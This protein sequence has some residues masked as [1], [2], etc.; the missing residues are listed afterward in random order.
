M[1][2]NR[3][4]TVIQNAKGAFLKDPQRARPNE[5]AGDRPL[6]KPPVYLSKEEK[7][8]WKE[9]AEQL[10]PGVA[11]ESDRTMFELLVRLKTQMV[12]NFAAMRSADKSLLK[13]L[14]SRFA[15]S[16]ADRSKVAVEAPKEG[17]LDKFL[18]KLPTNS[19]PEEQQFAN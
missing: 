13:D 2:R 3:I 7:K 17:A 19:P 11:F 14:S 1:G 10:L 12:H 8:V 16:P 4:P 5:P 15:M 9:L 18:R 6:G